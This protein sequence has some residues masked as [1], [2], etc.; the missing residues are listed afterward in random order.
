MEKRTQANEL[1]I[2]VQDDA[3][4]APLEIRRHRRPPVVEFLKRVDPAA[5]RLYFP[6]TES[7]ELE[8]L[9][10]MKKQM[11]NQISWVLTAIVVLSNTKGGKDVWV[12]AIPLTIFDSIMGNTLK[13]ERFKADN[14]DVYN[15]L[16]PIGVM[17]LYIYNYTLVHLGKR[18][19][20]TINPGLDLY[21]QTK[22][23]SRQKSQ[24]RKITRKRIK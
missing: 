20:K 22:V 7:K 5:E 12:S 16:I 8:K 6:G 2:V 18:L 17:L 23:K 21:K 13:G 14:K 19:L 10:D 1:G 3:T 9:A 15:M 24:K 11:V 4:P